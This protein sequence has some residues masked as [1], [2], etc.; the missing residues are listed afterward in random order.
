MSFFDSPLGE[1]L[2]TSLDTG[3]P[4]DIAD[5][6]GAVQKKVWAGVVESEQVDEVLAELQRNRQLQHV[7]DIA[8][9]ATAV[10]SITPPWAVAATARC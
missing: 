6:V 10:D 5:A 2:L 7:I 3:K 4:E 8:D 1:R 9:A